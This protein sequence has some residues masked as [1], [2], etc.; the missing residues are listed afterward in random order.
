ML[1][2]SVLSVCVGCV[3]WYLHARSRDRYFN[4]DTAYLVGAYLLPAV[5]ALVTIVV[6]TL[7]M[8]RTRTAIVFTALL[9]AVHTGEMFVYHFLDANQ[10]SAVRR[11]F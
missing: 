2:G 6:I 7:C 5:V 8:R 9:I 11:N 10:K 4:Q 3:F 1:F